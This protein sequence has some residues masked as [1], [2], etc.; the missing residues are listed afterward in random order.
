MDAKQQRKHQ[1]TKRS[2]LQEPL[3]QINSTSG[4]IAHHSW[5][6]QT[7]SRITAL[8]VLQLLRKYALRQG[9]QVYIHQQQV[10]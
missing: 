7:D 8:L 6:F 3:I 2:L 5:Q 10:V 1:N 4:N 9:V